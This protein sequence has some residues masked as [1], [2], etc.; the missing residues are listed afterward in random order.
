VHRL[1]DADVLAVVESMNGAR[2]I[3]DQLELAGGTCASPMRARALA[4]PPRPL[5]HVGAAR[6][7]GRVRP[8]LNLY[9]HPGL[10]YELYAGL[11]LGRSEA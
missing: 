1:G 7:R 3:H 11:T 9:A 4:T 10:M 2:F 6:R 8:Y 5:L